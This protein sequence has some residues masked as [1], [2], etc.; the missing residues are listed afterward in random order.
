[1]CELPKHNFHIKTKTI[2]NVQ[3]H[4]T[5]SNFYFFFSTIDTNLSFTLD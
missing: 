3:L 1:M 5:D 2:Y 4:R